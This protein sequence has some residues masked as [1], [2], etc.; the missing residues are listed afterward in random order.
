M[1][2]SKPLKGPELIDCARANAKQ[3][4]E[5]ATRL[6]G[7]GSDVR[8]FSQ[9]LHQACDRIGVHVEE[10]GDLITDQQAIQE[11]QGVEVAPDTPNH[12]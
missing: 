2:Q 5:T 9:S 4:L 6:C 10:L 8:A 7:Y 11:Q 3:G 1:T 12:L